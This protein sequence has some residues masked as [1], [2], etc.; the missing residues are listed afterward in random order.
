VTVGARTSMTMLTVAQTAGQT[1][2]WAA[3]VAA[4]PL[5]LSRPHAATWVA[6]ITI[7]WGGLAAISQFTTRRL[8]DRFGP[9]R[10]GACS[11]TFAAI[12][13]IAAAVTAQNLAAV[14]AALGLMSA[15][16][17]LAV[18]AGDV[19][20]TWLPHRPDL[21]RAGSWLMLA[22]AVPVLAGPLG[23]ASLLTSYGPRA[24]WLAVAGLFLAAAAGTA[25]VPAVRP[26]LAT[27]A[28]AAVQLRW[29]LKILGVLAITAGVWLT[30]G[31]MTVLQPLYVQDELHSTLVT[32]GWTMAAFAAGG[33]GMALIALRLRPLVEWQWSVPLA[34]L[35]T[36][37]GERLFTATTS[38][39]VAL[40]GLLLWGASA[41][42]FSLTSRSVIVSAVP[43]SAHGRSLGLWR[44]TQ[45]AA[46]II[47]AL[48]VGQ[49]IA[50]EGLRP[51]AT[52]TCALA[53][54][55]GVA[56]LACA[57][58]AN[59]V[60]GRQGSSPRRASR[61]SAPGVLASPRAD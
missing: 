59:V 21:T 47:P 55:C 58:A 27:Q 26:G 10:I 8:V 29:L 39:P 4:L 38:V 7:A 23:S 20:P 31:A 61:A 30:Y 25:L 52:W 1:G 49:L 51:V 42:M 16:R 37:G 9:R 28:A 17:G 34:A 2:S 50:I 56:Y 57:G 44:G 45:A 19:A 15:T 32:Y 24:A 41:A 12:G 35:A 3:L 54:A 60:R 6:M 40:I 53:G 14:V 13:A 48:A 11:W 33:I 5:A 36:A 22:A 43:P 46:N 18:V